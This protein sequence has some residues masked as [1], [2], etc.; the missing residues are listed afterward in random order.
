[1]VFSKYNIVV[2]T[3]AN[4][5]VIYNVLRNKV[6]RLTDTYYSKINFSN[7]SSSDKEVLSFLVDNRFVVDETEEH[8]AVS[9]KY[10]AIID[11]NSL[12]LTIIGTFACNFSCPYC[13][14]DHSSA[15]RLKKADYDNIIE[16]ISRRNIR[17]VQVNLF[18]GEPLLIAKDLLSFINR[19]RQ[20][21]I[22]IHGGIT[23]NGYLLDDNVFKEL[24]EANITDFQ[25]TI[26]GNKEIHDNQRCLANKAPTYDVIM[27]NLKTIRQS[28][29]NCNITVRCN[30]YSDT[31]IDTFLSDYCSIIGAD[32][33]FSLL[34][35]PV[36]DWGGDRMENQPKTCKTE[37]IKKYTRILKRLQINNAYLNLLLNGNIFCD[38]CLNDSFVILPDG[39]IGK[40]TIDFSNF[41]PFKDYVGRVD[42]L[43]KCLPACHQTDCVLFPKCFGWVCPLAARENICKDRKQELIA[44]LKEYFS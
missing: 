28:S 2:K 37:L 42:N 14:E 16:Y 39:K 33:R 12:Y 43:S 30:L 7:L 21:G 44:F 25:I 29:L 32:K 6:I 35:Y 27:G 36:S 24:V 34:L 22:S 17:K 5:Y 31:R 9:D 8:Q 4:H 1:M 3:D 38:Y 15:S 11:S 41:I 10:H 40:C 26:D 19:L 20:L 23:T 18:G 13:Y